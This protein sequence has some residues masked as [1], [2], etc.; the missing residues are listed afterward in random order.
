MYIKLCVLIFFFG[1]FWIGG[2]KIVCVNEREKRGDIYI[3]N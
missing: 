2:L 1:G 3:Y